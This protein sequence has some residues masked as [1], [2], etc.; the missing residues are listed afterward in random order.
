MEQLC[1]ILKKKIEIKARY[2]CNLHFYP[3]LEQYGKV[4]KSNMV[5]QLTFSSHSLLC[6]ILS[7]GNQLHAEQASLTYETVNNLIPLLLLHR[8][9]I[10]T[11]LA[12]AQAHAEQ[13]GAKADR[14][15]SPSAVLCS[16]HQHGREC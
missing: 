7:R 16:L 5:H 10:F 14:I 6:S 2:N 15:P 13:L 4:R 12:H 9:T 11:W 8:G 3:L 1:F